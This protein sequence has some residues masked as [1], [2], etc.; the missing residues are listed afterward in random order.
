M[1]HTP[2]STS[3]GHVRTDTNNT[4]MDMEISDGETP[5]RKITSI[6]PAGTKKTELELKL[7]S[8]VKISVYFVMDHLPSLCNLGCLPI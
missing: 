5:T 4:D 6:I 2:T 3:T 8:S 1:V 7:N